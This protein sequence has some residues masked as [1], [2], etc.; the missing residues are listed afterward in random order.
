MDA[1]TNHPS[2][3]IGGYNPPSHTA[4]SNFFIGGNA[5]LQA[6][7]MTAHPESKNVG[8]VTFSN[9]TR[10]LVSTSMEKGYVVE[11]RDAT[12]APGLMPA[13]LDVTTGFLRP[14]FEVRAINGTPWIQKTGNGG[15]LKLPS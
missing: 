9:G 8:V 5:N 13:F 1:P 2:G 3:I 7:A 15:G 4:M 12:G 11:A 14:G 6:T 10:A